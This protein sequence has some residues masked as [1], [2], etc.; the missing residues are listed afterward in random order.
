MTSPT[1]KHLERARELVL[2]IALFLCRPISMN[3]DGS[4]VDTYE[5]KSAQELIAHAL[6][7]VEE[8]TREDCCK[9]VCGLCDEGIIPVTFREYGGLSAWVHRE[10]NINNPCHAAA[11]RRKGGES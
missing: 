2:P 1:E 3:P 7:Q 10:G 5:G 6:I 8:E 9:L 11:I 4:I